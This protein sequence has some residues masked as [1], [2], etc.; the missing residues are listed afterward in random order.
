MLLQ[1]AILHGR[2]KDYDTALAIFDAIEGAQAGNGLG[3]IEWSEKGLML[4]RLGRYAEAFA[5]FSEG[6]RLLAR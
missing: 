1:R 2:L 5:A 3:P 4:D 6:K